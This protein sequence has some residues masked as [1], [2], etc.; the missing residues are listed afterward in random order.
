M[1]VKTGLEKT[2]DSLISIFSPK[3]AV[4]RKMYRRSLNPSK[5]KR[6]AQYAA[7]KTSRLTGS[8]SP[9]DTNVNKIIG[10][11]SAAV[12]ARVRQ[13]VRDFSYFSRA[14]ETLVDH[15]VGEGIVYQSRVVGPDGKLAKDVNQKIEDAFKWWGDECDIANKLH[16]YE[17]MSL[18][19]RQDLECGEF[20][21]IPRL[22]RK[23]NRFIPFALQVIEPDWL[24]DINPSV[25]N[26]ENELDQGIEFNPDTGEVKYFHFAD[27]DKYG[28]TT[29]VK[30]SNVIHKFKT[31][32]PGQLRGISPFSPA[33]LITHDLHD[34]IEAEIDAAKLAAKYLAF[35]QKPTALESDLLQD[36]TGDDEGKKIDEMENAIIEYLA[37]GEEIKIA[38]HHRPGTSF[39]PTIKLLLCMVAATVGVPYELLSM[40]YQGM[41]YSTSRTVR[42]DFAHYLRPISGRHVRHFGMSTFKPFLDWSVLT[43]KLSLP[44]YGSNPRPFWKSEWQPPGMESLDPLRETKGMVEQ[45]KARLRSPQ[46]IARARGR[47]LE[48]IYKEIAEAQDLAEELGVEKPDFDSTSVAGNPAAVE[49]QKQLIV[50]G[51]GDFRE[52]MEIWLYEIIEAM[53]EKASQL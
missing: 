5:P 27:P 17:I 39:S 23:R 28:K 8:W 51:N 43:N 18:M 15:T 36:G 1:S 37:T 13:L 6:S 11:S 38:E 9:V 4:R 10:A 24:T 3:A 32:R 31:Y 29:R 45:L 40:D 14:V 2:V 12:R 42:N 49:G 41:N 48:D 46:E 21:I 16:Y 26:K 33:V 53:Q 30:A 20:L 7:A 19:K 50:K 35:V 52:D 34:Y 44:G 22:S 25:V 47:D